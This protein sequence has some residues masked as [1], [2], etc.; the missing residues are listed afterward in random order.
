MFLAEIIALLVCGR[1]LGEVMTRIGQPAVMGQLIAG[2]LLG[3]SVLGAIW[4]EFQHWLF[5]RNPEQRAMI[6]AVAQLG[7]LLLLLVTGME[8]DL[9]VVRRSRRTAFAVSI[10]GILVPFLCG[11]V[12]GELLPASMLP[13]PERRLVT[14][15]FLGTAL[16]ISSVKIVAMVVRE[17]GFLR[18]TIGQ[19]IVAAAIIDDTIGWIVMSVVFGLALHGAI[20]FGSLAWSLAGVAIFLLLSFTIGRR[21]VFRLIR[22]TNDRFQ[23]ELP[24]ITAILVATGIMALTTNAIGV[25]TVL[26]A[27][28]AGILVGQSPILTRHIDE[29]LR[30]LIVALFMPVFFG[31]A[32]LST[33]LE[34]LANP[35]LLLLTVGLIAI[36][37]I[38]KFGGAFL[39][40]RLG[41]MNWAEAMALG[42]GMNARGSTEV[43]VASIGL[44][45]GVLNQ[46]LFTTIVAMA[47]VTTMSMPPMLR[48]ALGRLPLTPRRR[49]AWTRRHSRR[50]GSSPISNACSSR[51][52]QA[53]AGNSPLGWSVCSRDARHIP[54]TVIHF[55][56]EQEAAPQ[57]GAE[58]AQR[59]K[60]VIEESADRGDEAAVS[61]PGTDR[62]EIITK[63]IKPDESAIQTEA[64]KGYGF[65]LIGREPA[66]EGSRFHD[67]IARSA[68]AFDGPF[69]I[70]IARGSDR[71]EGPGRPF[72]ILVPVTG[73]LFSRH[74]AEMAI[75]LAQASR[76]TVTALHVAAARRT[77]YS[78]RRVGAA[79]APM[80]SSDAIIRE[81][82]R[83]GETYG[84]EVRGAV[85][86]DGAAS[87]EI[88]RQVRAGGHNLLVMGVSPR[89]GEDLFFGDV[90]SEL[91][92]DCDCSILFISEP[93]NSIGELHETKVADFGRR[94]MAR[95]RG[96]CQLH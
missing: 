81:I 78:W 32:G 16:S 4:P 66:S 52:M 54:T 11:V 19:V 84:V 72:N 60:S 90:P 44:S 92:A 33:N 8:T 62:V 31:M 14:T 2:I 77:S 48:W 93:P 94:A 10:C 27:F 63:V 67:Q 59:T 29:Q 76:G 69:G 28:I 35:N 17:V 47:V 43:I 75:A 82:V 45:M 53:R 58:Q 50:R 80:S 21:L 7:I 40:G 18:R 1:V 57:A 26:G 70:A 12:L 85:R 9:S 88:L 86:G 37:S 64:R 46:D 56:Y 25:H 51:S 38:G 41:G 79:I 3:P 96:G 15:L 20:D 6:D 34:V 23:S 91:L 36:A 68:V 73:T 71:N 49:R 74:G 42:C 95:A 83:L 5:P 61:E 24:V 87:S 22:W 39:G 30:G 65:L 13:D 55:D 89:P